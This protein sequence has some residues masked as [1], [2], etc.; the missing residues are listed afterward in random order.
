MNILKKILGISE[1]P[2]KET[3][4]AASD[5]LHQAI[6]EHKEAV[7]EAKKVESRSVTARAS[8]YRAATQALRQLKHH[9]QN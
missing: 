2:T 8:A 4:D 7:E 1:S 5:E 6:E 9:H 3:V